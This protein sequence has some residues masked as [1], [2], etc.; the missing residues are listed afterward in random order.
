MPALGRW[1]AV[2]FVTLARPGRFGIAIFRGWEILLTEIANL[3]VQAISSILS[4][5]GVY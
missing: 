3:D 5:R 4:E 1:G 2:L